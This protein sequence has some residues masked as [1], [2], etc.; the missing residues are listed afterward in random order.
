MRIVA[1]TVIMHIKNKVDYFHLCFHFSTRISFTNH[2][3][4]Q[5]KEI[6]K[7]LLVFNYGN[8]IKYLIYLLYKYL[9]V[10][11]KTLN[12]ILDPQIIPLLE[13]HFVRIFI[14]TI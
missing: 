6:K 14:N 13:W 10:P 1:I 8:S 3:I 2:V 4:S 11:R 12:I 9:S 5:F 7:G